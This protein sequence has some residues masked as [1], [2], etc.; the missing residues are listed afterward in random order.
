[1]L[2]ESKSS[3]LEIISGGHIRPVYQPI[4]SLQDGSV[5]GYEA[6]S[7]ITLPDCALQIE[8]LFDLA[9][10]TQKLWELER[11]CRMQAL[12]NAASKPAGARLFL[13]VDPNIIYDPAFISGFTVQMLQE[14]GLNPDEV[15]FEITEKR[16]IEATRAFSSA[17]KHYQE[18]NFQVAIDDFGSGYSGLLRACSFSPDYLKIDMGIVRGI[19]CDSRKKSVMSGIVSFCREAGI[20][21][22]AEGVETEEELKTLVQ[23]GVEYG[24]GFFLARPHEQFEV[25]PSEVKLL[26]KRARNSSMNLESAGQTFGSVGAICRKS[27]AVRQNEA[28]LTVYESMC[29]DSSITEVCVVNT[30]GAVLGLLT[31]EHL[32][33]RFSGQFGYSLCYRRE[34]RDLL[35]CEFLSVDSSMTID[36]V[37]AQAMERPTKSVYDAVVVT[38]QGKYFGIV[39][40]RDLLNAAI[41]IR[42]KNAA[43]ASPL[44]GLPGNNAIQ[45][46]ID[47]VM[48][49][50]RPCAIVYLDLDNFKAYNDAYGFGCG[51]NML[52]LVAQAMN[53]CC[54]A[55]DFKGHI[56]GDDFVIITRDTERLPRLCGKIISVFSKMLQP[57]YSEEDWERGYIIS[58]N[59]NGFSEKFSIAT[60]SIA[61][62]TNQSISFSEKD[63][64]SKTIAH[65]KKQCKAKQG[66]AVAIV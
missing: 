47:E 24:Q 55:A 8:Q 37:A 49:D 48:G 23:I 20:F 35:D 62:V 65:A 32:L 43:D 12:K 7:R 66:H 30:D 18:Q 61:A 56:G 44:T 22:I 51:D 63:Q 64:L 41:N 53:L 21:L 6:L 50:E 28:A 34:V 36:S 33:G 13:N 10:M 60:L 14:F 25:V 15:I 2:T 29:A 46:R 4:V 11:L 39:T 19:H 42:V 27:N 59:R 45:R 3:L 57:L 52:K 40:V 9:A 1:M 58:K 38:Q 17:I 26:I 16:T 31:R 5:F 54:S